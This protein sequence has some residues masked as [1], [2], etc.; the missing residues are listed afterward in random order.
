MAVERN[1]LDE[2]YHLLMLAE[3]MTVSSTVPSHMYLLAK[4]ENWQQK[5]RHVT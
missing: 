5:Q 3:T 2:Y 1:R 4:N